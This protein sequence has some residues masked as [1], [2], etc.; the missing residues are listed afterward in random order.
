M[1]NF[2]HDK[3]GEI[4]NKCVSESEPFVLIFPTDVNINNIIDAGD[5]EALLKTM[6]VASFVDGE[7]FSMNGL[8]TFAILKTAH[9]MRK[10]MDENSKILKE[11]GIEKASLKIQI[12]MEPEDFTCQTFSEYLSLCRVTVF[13]PSLDRWPYLDVEKEEISTKEVDNKPPE[14]DQSWRDE[15]EQL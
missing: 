14:G 6:W 1:K 2:N 15:K 5:T 3:V 7:D 10:R 9:D 4:C 11:K 12:S 8:E 13:P